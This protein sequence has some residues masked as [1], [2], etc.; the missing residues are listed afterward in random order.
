MNSLYKKLN[1]KN[2]NKISV[3]PAR[4]AV[5]FDKWNKE[6]VLITG[7][8]GFIGSHT[9]LLLLE[10]GF[11]IFIL[12]SFSNSSIKSLENV[13]EILKRK[14]LELKEKLHIIKGD[15]KNKGDL[16][17]IF[18]IFTLNFQII[19]IYFWIIPYKSRFMSS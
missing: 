13:S 10:K 18:E 3:E 14:G 2:S 1:E 9:C 6:K 17:K 8:A 11:T 15:L 5:E 12:D 19:L 4:L 16:E 7:G